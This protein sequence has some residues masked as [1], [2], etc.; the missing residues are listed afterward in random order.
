MSRR[1]WWEAA[2]N[3][4]RDW[5]QQQINKLARDSKVMGIYVGLLTNQNSGDIIES[6]IEVH[7]GYEN[8]WGPLLKIQ[9]R[10]SEKCGVNFS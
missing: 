1:V 4:R 5:R 6:V 2:T 7:S 9:F 8:K 10:T 3:N